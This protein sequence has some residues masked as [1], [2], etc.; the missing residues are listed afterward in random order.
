MDEDYEHVARTRRTT[1]EP[2][3]HRTP[4][5]LAGA[6]IFAVFA[7]LIITAATQTTRNAVSD[8]K[9]RQ[10][11]L[12]QV[13]SRQASYDVERRRLATLQ[14]STGSLQSELL[15]NS[16]QA[17]G[18][19]TE[20]RNLSVVAGTSPVRGSGVKVVVDD[21]P[22]AQNAR[23]QVLDSDLQKLANGLWEAGAEAISINGQ[24]L[25]NLSAIREAGSAI[26][27]NY[28]SLRRPYTVLAVGNPN[29]L[30]A[31][32]ADT[33]SGQAWLDLQ[34]QV[35]LRFRMQQRRSLTLPAA[36]TPQLRF[37]QKPGVRSKNP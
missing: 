7:V 5:G 30:P 2:A 35:G 12:N 1:G 10:D 34:Q 22:G 20:L 24:R 29:T 3:N 19:L 15:S 14:Q 6:V 21:A 18:L 36:P 37:A 28:K 17:S 27:V 31:R 16:Q 23:N 26:T 13:R 9:E 4:S 8:A 32:F 25:S 33:T 11:L